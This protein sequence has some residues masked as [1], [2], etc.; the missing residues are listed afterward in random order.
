MNMQNYPK[1]EITGGAALVLG[2]IVLGILYIDRIL[3]ESEIFSFG[4]LIFWLGAVILLSENLDGGTS[5]VISFV[6]GFG[7]ILVVI[8]YTAYN[9]FITII[10]IIAVSI[11]AIFAIFVF[12]GGEN[13]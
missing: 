2:G 1:I 8:F 13:R 10:Q 12:F 6:A 3:A 11:L 7:Y 4:A 5:I 9:L